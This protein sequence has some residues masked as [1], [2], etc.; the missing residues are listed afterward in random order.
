M[1]LMINANGVNVFWNSYWTLDQLIFK[2]VLRVNMKWR[3]NSRIRGEIY[4]VFVQQVPNSNNSFYKYLYVN[5]T[6]SR[7]SREK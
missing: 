7:F 3:K 6:R 1:R 5:I 2:V 4:S